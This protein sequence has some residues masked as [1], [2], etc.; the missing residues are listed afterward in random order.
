MLARAPRA[1]VYEWVCAFVCGCACACVCMNVCVRACVH[2][3]VLVCL[4][5]VCVRGRTCQY[6]VSDLQ[7]LKGIESKNAYIA[8]ANSLWS[9]LTHFK[10]HTLMSFSVNLTKRMR[11]SLCIIATVNLKKKKKS[12]LSGQMFR[13]RELPS[14]RQTLLI[15]QINYSW[16]RCRFF[17]SFWKSVKQQWNKTKCSAKWFIWHWTDLFFTVLYCTAFLLNT[18]IYLF[19]TEKYLP[20]VYALKVGLENGFAVAFFK[21]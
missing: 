6:G 21:V 10:F 14:K 13:K 3:W 8:N 18:V 4:F 15:I 17:D 1:H 7:A 16:I 5:F 9:I 20:C 19:A 11:C 12:A 2:A